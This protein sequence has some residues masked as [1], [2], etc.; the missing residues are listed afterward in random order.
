MRSGPGSMFRG[1]A[2][3]DVESPILEEG[4]AGSGSQSG[5]EE[6]TESVEEADYVIGLDDAI[7]EITEWFNEC[8]PDQA[9]DGHLDADQ[10]LAGFSQ[11]ILYAELLSRT[12]DIPDEAAEALDSRLKPDPEGGELTALA[13]KSGP[14]F[15]PAPEAF[16]SEGGMVTLVPGLHAVLMSEESVLR[17]PVAYLTPLYSLC[18]SVPV[19]V[20]P[21]W[22]KGLISF[23]SEHCAV[24]L[25]EVAATFGLALRGKPV[26]Y[27]L[28]ASYT[29]GY[30]NLT[31]MLVAVYGM[32][33]THTKSES[34][35]T[36]VLRGSHTTWSKIIPDSLTDFHFFNIAPSPWRFTSDDDIVHEMLAPAEEEIYTHRGKCK[37]NHPTVLA[38]P[39]TTED[40]MSRYAE[41]L[42]QAGLTVTWMSHTVDPTEC[43]IASEIYAGLDVVLCRHSDFMDEE[44]VRTT[45]V[46]R[47]IEMHRAS[48]R[49]VIAMEGSAFVNGKWTGDRTKPF[50]LPLTYQMGWV[51]SGGLIPRCMSDKKLAG[52]PCVL[53]LGVENNGLMRTPQEIREHRDETDGSRRAIMRATNQFDPNHVLRSSGT[54]LPYKQNVAL[55]ELLDAA[56]DA[57]FPRHYSDTEIEAAVAGWKPLCSVSYG[58]APV[59]AAQRVA[60]ILCGKKTYKPTPEKPTAVG[61]ILQTDVEVVA[62]CRLIPDLIPV[63]SITADTLYGR[64]RVGVACSIEYEGRFNMLTRH[65]MQK[66]LGPLYCRSIPAIR[67]T[68]G[69]LMVGVRGET[70][71]DLMFLRTMQSS[72]LK[73]VLCYMGQT[74]AQASASRAA[75]HKQ[76]VRSKSE[77]AELISK[78]Y[79]GRADF[80]D[81]DLA[82]HKEEFGEARFY[83]PECRRVLTPETVEALVGLTQDLA[84][85]KSLSKY[86]VE[87]TFYQQ[88]LP[89]GECMVVYLPDLGVTRTR[90]FC[91]GLR[92]LSLTVLDISSVKTPSALKKGL[93]TV[94]H[95]IVASRDHGSATP[96]SKAGKMH[97]ALYRCLVKEGVRLR[98]LM[99]LGKDINPSAEA[100]L[101]KLY[102]GLAAFVLTH[103]SDKREGG[104]VADTLQCIPLRSYFE[105]VW[106]NLCG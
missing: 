56:G 71:I 81:I 23:N 30:G 13:E 15:A 47:A 35:V 31:T 73:R 82:G 59:P 25:A 3:F 58:K 103:Y 19:G 98:A 33:C 63:W 43:A 75:I 44:D 92:A 21:A 8:L 106:F 78:G 45:S 102:E 50:F 83:G 76:I 22:F 29:T 1:S 38:M 90:T 62:A 24:R 48:A 94:P 57:R 49:V 104:I 9:I 51:P 36:S 97:A 5:S 26:Q 12:L 77:C 95:V 105:D 32:G 74:E 84:V 54:L 34:T 41:S 60:D 100:T 16:V 53:T 101:R 37:A 67:K 2:A 96:Q 6:W 70:L 93:A 14:T 72:V 69:L 40:H 99:C 10:F 91:D 27:H 89:P 39:F 85:G 11:W 86:T 17:D 46:W 66:M 68:A 18:L 64:T 88:V 52:Q 87:T 20:L 80:K 79:M 7:E 28:F 42:R 65:Q 55:T 4:S 61:V